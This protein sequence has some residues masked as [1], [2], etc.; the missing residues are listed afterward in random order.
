MG[1]GGGGGHDSVLIFSIVYIVPR[2]VEVMDV[3]RPCLVLI[4]QFAPP[5]VLVGFK[6]IYFHLSL[7]IHTYI[8]VPVL[9]M[10]SMPYTIAGQ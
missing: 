1:G 9:Y 3:K 5:C 4:I 10:Y 7:P 6:L 8:R 2:N